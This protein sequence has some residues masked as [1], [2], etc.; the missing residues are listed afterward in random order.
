MRGQDEFVCSIYCLIA[1]T[2]AI[3]VFGWGSWRFLFRTRQAQL[4]A[5]E[6]SRRFRFR[7][8]A[9]EKTIMSKATFWEYRLI[10]LLSGMS[11]LFLVYILM[12]NIIKRWRT[13]L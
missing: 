5:V 12:E 10:G 1:N 3:L 13:A 7:F 4:I 11:A 2:L 6:K 8:M 9:S